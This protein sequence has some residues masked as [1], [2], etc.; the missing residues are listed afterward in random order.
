MWWCVFGILGMCQNSFSWAHRQSKRFDKKGETFQ[1]FLSDSRK[2]I[3]LQQI[4]SG[5]K[6]G[7]FWKPIDLSD[8]R[9]VEIYWD[10]N[11]IGLNLVKFSFYILLRK[12][13]TKQMSPWEPISLAF[14]WLNCPPD[15]SSFMDAPQK[16][17]L[18]EIID[19]PLSW[20]IFLDLTLY[21]WKIELFCAALLSTQ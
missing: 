19:R 15:A 3:V 5:F 1:F 18:L 4:D 11:D 9:S 2:F 17:E 21:V 8:A 12:N 20:I 14:I 13:T 6:L 10:A 7:I 16:R